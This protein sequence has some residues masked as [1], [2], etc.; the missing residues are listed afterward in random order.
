MF[1]KEFNFEKIS[2]IAEIGMTHDGSFGLAKKLTESAIES[3]ADIIKYQWHIAEEETT[4]HAP[5]P[6]YFKDESRFEYFKRTEFSVSQFKALGALCRDNGVIPCVSVFSV[7]SVRRAVEAGF[8]IIK[9]PSG[10]VTNTPMLRE[11]AKTNLPIIL[12]SGM[13][14]WE[15]LD[16]AVDALGVSGSLCILQ[17]SSMYPTPPERVGLNVLDII[18]KR[19]GTCVGLSDHTLTSATAIAAVAMGA[20]VIEKH[21]TISKKLFGPDARFSLEPIEFSQ[22]VD[23]ID[24]VSK[25]LAASIDK[26]DLAS[27]AEMKEIFQKSI[28][29]KILIEPGDVLTIDNL[30]FKKPGTGIPASDV[31]LVV[32]KKY[33]ATAMPDDEI[34]REFLL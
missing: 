1:V 32:G 9:I 4:L 23:D 24:F 13:S 7:E 27:Y 26:D 33:S 20:T 34:K 15:E 11:V 22:L 17:C 14:N 18:K 29:A 10:E 28:V 8:D 12:S 31:D 21:F 3:G 16:R 30:A 5:S 19:Y 2:V 25:A 6:P